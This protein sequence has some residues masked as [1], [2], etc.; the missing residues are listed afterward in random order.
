MKN[1]TAAVVAFC[2]A[3][4]CVVTCGATANLLHNSGFENAGTTAT[5]A[6]YWESGN[7]DLHGDASG[8]AA[9]E[10]WRNSPAS[11]G[12]YEATIKGHWANAGDVGEWWQ[13]VPGYANTEYRFDGWFWSDLGPTGTVGVKI[14]FYDRSTLVHGVTNQLFGQVGAGWTNNS[15]EATAP[16]TCDW[17]RVVVF[18]REFGWNGAFQFDDLTLEVVGSNQFTRYVSPSGSHTYP[19][20]NW[21]TAATNIQ[22]AVDVSKTGE[23]VLLTNGTYLLWTTIEVT[24]GIT[25]SS[26]NGADVTVIDGGDAVRCIDL[27]HSNATLSR[28]TI[29]HGDADIAGGI[30]LSDG[31]RIVDCVVED[32]RAFGG[33]TVPGFYGYGG[34]IF[35][36]AGGLISGCTIADNYATVGY[37][38]GIYMKDGGTVTNCTIRNN[39]ADNGGS[40]PKGGYGGGIYCATNGTIRRC[41]I[42]G[43]FAG[44]GGGV[45]CVAGWVEGCT[46]VNNSA[47]YGYYNQSARG[48]G[49]ME[50]GSL[51]ENCVVAENSS[52]SA[53]GL[54]GSSGGAVR[55][56][57]IVDNTATAGDGGGTVNA[58][59]R[60]CIVWGNAA[61]ES[62]SNRVGGTAVYSDSNPL[63]AGTGNINADPTFVTLAR[64]YQLTGNSPCIDRGTSVD[65]SPVDLLGALRPIDGDL[66]S[67]AGYDMGAYEYDPENPPITNEPPVVDAGLRQVI[68]LP[69]V[70]SLDA[71]VVD[72]DLP[73]T[74]VTYQWSFLSGPGSVSFGDD[75]AEDTTA[76]FSTNGIY[77]LR[78]TA[79]DGELTGR[80]DVQVTVGAEPVN[81]PPRVTLPDDNGD[82][83]FPNGYLNSDIDDDGMPTNLVLTMEW[84]VE[85]APGPVTIDSPS[86]EDSAVTFTTN[87]TH[88]FRMTVSDGACTSSATMS[89]RVG[90]FGNDK[91]S[92]MLPFSNPS[93][94]M[95]NASLLAGTV[96]DDGNPSGTL[97]STWSKVSGPGTVTFADPHATN[98]T[99]N[100]SEDGRYVLE[101]RADDGELQDEDTVIVYV[102]P[103]YASYRCPLVN[104][105]LT[106][107]GSAPDDWSATG[108]DGH[109]PD[110]V[111]YISSN[112]AWTFSSD[113]TI[114]QD[115]SL[116]GL[117]AGFN[118]GFSGHLFTPSSDPLRNGSK[119]GV[120][121]LE[122]YSNSTVAAA[123]VTPAID[124]NSIQDTWMEVRGRVALSDAIT[125]VRLSAGVENASDGEGRFIADD[126]YLG[127]AATVVDNNGGTNESSPALVAGRPAAAYNSAGRL[128]FAI[129]SSSNGYGTWT[130]TIVDTNIPCGAVDLALVDGRPAIAYQMAGDLKFAINS[131]ADGSGSWS[132]LNVDTDVVDGIS[133]SLA[134]V[135]GRPAVAAISAVYYPAPK[136]STTGYF[137]NM[138]HS[139]EVDGSGL[140]SRNEITNGYYNSY[141]GVLNEISE[142][143]LTIIDGRPAVA[144]D[145]G[146]SGI[147]FAINSE[148]DMSGYWTSYPIFEELGLSSTMAAI[149]LVNIGGK[150]AVACSARYN[151]LYLAMSSTADGSGPW[152]NTDLGEGGG[153]TWHALA[154]VDGKPALAF[155]RGGYCYPDGNTAVY[156][157]KNA[158]ADASG[159]WS[160]YDLLLDAGR[161]ESCSMITKD[162]KPMI[163][164]GGPERDLRFLGAPG[165]D[166]DSDGLSDDDEVYVYGTSPQSADSDGDGIQ[167]G[168]EA[169][170]LG[171]NPLNADTDGDGM[172]DGDELIAG[173]APTDGA[174]VFAS[175]DAAWDA[176]SE[177]YTFS[178]DTLT[179][180]LYT[181]YRAT[182]LAGPWTAVTGYI[183]LAGTGGTMI[184]IGSAAEETEYFRVKVRH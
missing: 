38:G 84:T 147:W 60:N 26:I 130:T 35:M 162:G 153:V 66:D 116:A 184:Y 95:P 32:N 157:T 49:I 67:T 24:N 108:V 10:N 33:P 156:Y 146:R 64:D 109:D 45:A 101:L 53:G 166:S 86:S 105:E 79:D 14:E 154:E 107:S 12:S 124:E 88:V 158:A 90:S 80:G 42:E 145:R 149:S 50:S 133:A 170:L 59:L 83:T 97:T 13:E 81:Q 85:S 160:R 134:V 52:G 37:G 159:V 48:G 148:A 103:P 182:T 22:A 57:T 89:L 44:S 161:T 168:A 41:L 28:L 181:V 125:S 29:Q 173:T 139:A 40:H 94:R 78:L 137:L 140:W 104:P 138:Y 152:S 179:G 118:V 6:E 114:Y 112:N 20:T 102:D 55:H 19:F 4:V 132:V 18:A 172:K 46:V 73:M 100:F 39:T 96:T 91:P 131:A 142:C 155:T 120:I 5:K 165:A 117:D 183:D 25:L 143:D 47:P 128:A 69:A 115:V 119:R 144:H 141:G 11:A 178:W 92:V 87:G 62:N 176:S 23:R 177:L 1:L 8:A 151:G 171:T 175:E 113:G 127:Y 61:Y 99:A 17:V 150:P 56:C 51:I 31:G 123:G 54:S 106:G 9:R 71:T 65:A 16:G 75:T 122:L 27:L 136:Y 93:V 21:A 74:N 34:G 167:D 180:Q 129:C 77:L 164:Y 76:S 163:L 43:N 98:T 63:P 2:V 7:P 110:T 126:L 174:S 15:F 36:D 111:T 82:V 30:Y 70:A 68:T 135:D 72:D 121:R 169:M 3:W 58:N